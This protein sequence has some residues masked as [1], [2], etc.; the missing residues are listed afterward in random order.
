MSSVGR[1]THCH[2]SSGVCA[3]KKCA[4]SHAKNPATVKQDKA[5][6]AKT[7]DK[8]KYE[9]VDMNIP[10][11]EGHMDLT[12]RTDTLLLLLRYAS[13]P[14]HNILRLLSIRPGR[15]VWGRISTGRERPVL[16]PR[17]QYGRDSVESY[18]PSDARLNK[19]TNDKQEERMKLDGI[20]Q[21]EEN[22]SSTHI[23]KWTH[24][25]K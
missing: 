24:V 15:L 3:T 7:C 21:E 16:W 8:N 17:W 19:Y 9:R 25:E 10:H 6:Q 22:S 1:V 20:K 5:K 13:S 11:R 4:V 23:I 14:P 12:Q 2:H 18:S